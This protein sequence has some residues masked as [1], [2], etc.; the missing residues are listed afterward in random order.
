VEEAVNDCGVS[1]GSTGHE[2]GSSSVEC[3]LRFLI[4]NISTEILD[5]Y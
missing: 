1:D 2:F 3:F 5:R 4:E